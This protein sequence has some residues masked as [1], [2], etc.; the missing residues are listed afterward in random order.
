[1]IT[2]KRLITNPDSKQ[3][4]S[5][6]IPESMPIRLMQV[7][8]WKIDPAF[9]NLS[10]PPVSIAVTD[11]QATTDKKARKRTISWN[12]VNLCQPDRHGLL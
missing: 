7:N 8:I 6:F 1:M 2:D 5:F 4:P 10:S 11:F 12:H 3:E 9:V